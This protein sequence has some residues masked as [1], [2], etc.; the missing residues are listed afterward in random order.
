VSECVCA[1]M[2]THA[3]VCVSE[4]E[5]QSFPL[6]LESR[7]ILYSVLSDVFEED[8]SVSLMLDLVASKSHVK[9]SDL[10][11]SFHWLSEVRHDTSED[12][13]IKHLCAHCSW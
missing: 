12:Q 10:H 9:H 2:H 4:R 13:E 8:T 6:P 5:F 3:H 1:C 7:C 11:S